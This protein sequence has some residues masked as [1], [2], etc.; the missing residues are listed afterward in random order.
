MKWP[1]HH[2][3]AI[4]NQK[5]IPVWDSCRCEFSLVNTPSDII[6]GGNHGGVMKYQLSSPA[7]WQ[8]WKLATVH[9]KWHI[10][11][12]TVMYG[13]KN[14]TTVTLQFLGSSPQTHTC[15]SGCCFSQVLGGEKRRPEIHLHSQAIDLAHWI[16]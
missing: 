2:V 14:T 12:A 16:Y 10:S 13:D 15:I 5:V 1:S 11:T 9:V 4:R 8:N 6:L 3:N 7:K